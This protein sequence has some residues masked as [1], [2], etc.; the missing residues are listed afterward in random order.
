MEERIGKIIHVA[1]PLGRRNRVDSPRL[2]HLSIKAL[3]GYSIHHHIRPH[4][5]ADDK[6]IDAMA[7]LNFRQ[8]RAR[9]KATR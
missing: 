5:V 9:R 8:T 3:D 7:A 6:T 4:S 2:A 1:L